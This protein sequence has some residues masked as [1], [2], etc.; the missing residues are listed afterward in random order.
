MTGDWLF[1]LTLQLVPRRWRETVRSDL[2]AESQMLRRGTL[3]RAWQT[4]RAAAHMRASF[5]GDAMIVD[6]RYAIRSLFRAGGFTFAAVL[7]FVLGIG[8]NLAVFTI[9]DRTLFRPLP[10]A[11]ADRLVMVTPYSPESGERHTAFNKQLFVEA[12]RTLA[13]IEDM[14]YAGFTFG[15]AIGTDPDAPATLG[16]TEV[17]YNLLEVL[18][19]V[20]VLG[21]PF[22]LDDLRT[23]R[24]VAMITFEA[25]QSKLGGSADVLRRTL[26]VGRTTREIVGVLPEGF[27]APALNRGA[28]FDGLYLAHESLDTYEPRENLDP[29]VARLRP[30]VAITVAQQQFDAL[31]AQLDPVLRGRNAT[32][33]PRVIVE[34]LRPAMFWTA[35]RYFWLVTLAASL[36]GL[37]AC[38]NLSSL[39]LARGRSHERDLAMRASL[40]ASRSRLLATELAQTLVLCALAAAVALVVLYWTASGLRALVPARMQPFVLSDI[41]AR[42]L[43]FALGA[44]VLGAFVGG[45]VPAWRASRINL[46][47]VLQTGAGAAGHARAGRAGRALLAFE[48]AVGVVLVAGAAVVLRSFIGLATN[49]LGFNPA[50]LHVVRVAPAG[51]RRGGDDAAELARFRGMLDVIRRQ[52]GVLAAGGVDSMPSSGAAPMTGADEW[53]GVHGSIGLWQVSEGFLSAIGARI[54]AGRDIGRDDL[55]HRRP[56]AI[57]SEAAARRLWPATPYESVLGR[58]LSASGQPPR[59]IVG[60]V[61]DIRDTP[62]R[63]ADPR[64]F[65]AAR[66]AG[67]WF[68]EYAVRTTQAG[69]NTEALHRTLA[70]S[71][72]ATR[73]SLAPGGSMRTSALRQPWMQTI[74]FGSF[75]VVGVLLAALGLFAVASFEVALRRHELGVRVAL[76]ASAAQIRRLML[77]DSLAPVALGVVC[78]LVIAHWTARFVQSLVHEVDARDP[79]TMA[80]VGAVLVVTTG[81]AAWLPARRA[82]RVDPVVTLRAQ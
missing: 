43:A 27:I 65:A 29:A 78:G 25:W 18:G 12:R 75:A 57:V 9:V 23:K 74:V 66:P 7:T 46:V 32:R 19:T 58:M 1:E 60:V 16:L 52:P 48:A 56:V 13:G 35:Y 59:R 30:G 69:L 14:A 82:A 24:N 44:V 63:P 15:H 20:P 73:V 2:L 81:L 47:A 8:V 11:H 77:A 38:A 42:V 10:F 61:A 64:I 4:L 80:L 31:A 50:G 41:D 68:L 45:I 40:G 36:V 3:W 72:G 76:G 6:S 54:V 53:N 55:D 70:A 17:S 67:F 22:S 37:L 21:R 26:R 51:D 71:H 79:W 33:G 62:I 5:S 34:R 39:L 28:R 49:D